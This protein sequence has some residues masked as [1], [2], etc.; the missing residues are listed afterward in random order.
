M[1]QL[2]SLNSMFGICQWAVKTTWLRIYRNTWI[3][4]PSY[5]QV[6]LYVDSADNVVEKYTDHADS[7]SEINP[8]VEED[9]ILYIESRLFP[10]QHSSQTRIN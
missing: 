7:H 10:F 5:I 4:N 6:N 2:Y 8:L 9:V 3:R 1:A